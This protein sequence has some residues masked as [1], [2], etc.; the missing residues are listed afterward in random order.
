MNLINFFDGEDD[1]ANMLVLVRDRILPLLEWID[2][3]ED[4]THQ[5]KAQTALFILLTYKAVT[6]HGLQKDRAIQ[7]VGGLIDAINAGDLDIP[8]SLH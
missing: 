6:E 2:A 3:H 5:V 1:L 4:S 8:L 7:I